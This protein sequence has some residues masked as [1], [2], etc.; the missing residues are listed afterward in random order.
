[1]AFKGW[2]AL[3]WITVVAS[4]STWGNSMS[5]VHEMLPLH[6]GAISVTL[7]QAMPVIFS[8]ALRHAP[9][10]NAFILLNPESNDSRSGDLSQA[11]DSLTSLPEPGAGALLGLGFLGI[12]ALAGR[13][14]IF[15]GE[16]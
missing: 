12:I 10:D 15:L 2:R 8:S 4:F 6:A 5:P 14:R 13:H 11:R 3:A 16:S 1:M 9:A 7:P